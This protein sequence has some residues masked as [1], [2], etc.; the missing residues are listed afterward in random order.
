MRIAYLAS[1]G[2]EPV[3]GGPRFRVSAL[4]RVFREL[5]EARLFCFE[6]P[7]GLA[8]RRELGRQGVS[9]WPPRREKGRAGIAWRHLEGGLAGRSIPGGRLFSPRRLARLRR[10]IAAFG[11]DVVVLDDAF[12]APLLPVLAPLGAKLVLSNH[13]AEARLHRRLAALAPS[14]G[15]R[16]RLG[17]MA[18][19]AEAMERRYF[20]LADQVWV[21]APPD[22]EALAAGGEHARV[23]PNVL[24][25][26]RYEPAVEEEA[27]AIVFSGTFTYLPNELA[28]NAL[29]EASAALDRWGVPHRL[30]LVGKHPS[31]RLRARA[32]ACPS[33]VLTGAVPDA[34]PF[35]ARAAVVAAPLT[36]GAGT[37]LKLLEGL[38]LG[39]AVLTTPVGAAGLDLAPG[40]ELEVR[41]PG[42]EFTASLA[43]LLNDPARRQ[44]LGQAG[45]AR[46]R[47]LY[48]LDAARQAVREAFSALG[49]RP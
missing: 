24:D 19:S 28:A 11:P 34:R 18:R 37:K 6:R 10:E 16:V 43:A 41:A 3:D 26:A 39:K 27:G 36:A 38:A 2:P 8:E 49:L 14:L 33:A 15:E 31:A 45:R 47:E 9:F 12:L 48:G 23:V 42:A 44:A 40:R 4:W 7:P 13:N 35:L 29:L 32:A 25:L 22:A 20:A 30:Y 1:V 5:G 21:P 46:V 17:L